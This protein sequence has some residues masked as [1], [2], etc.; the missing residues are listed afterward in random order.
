MDD[1]DENPFAVTSK[2]LDI[3]LVRGVTS[4]RSTSAEFC[5]FSCWKSILIF[6]SSH[7]SFLSTFL[8]FH[9]ISISFLFFYF[10]FFS[11]PYPALF[12]FSPLSSD[13]L[14]LFFFSILLLGFLFFVSCLSLPFFFF[15]Q[16]STLLSFS[17]I[18]FPASFLSDSCRFRFSSFFSYFSDFQPFC[19]FPCSFFLVA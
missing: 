5:P 14:P 9:C 6:F 10:L 4:F 3:M 15:S 2:P 12:P 13:F 8:F 16:I 1:R 7:F 19:P 17:F 11:F 18:L